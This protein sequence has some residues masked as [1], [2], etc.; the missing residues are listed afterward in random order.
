MYRRRLRIG[1]RGGS[2]L[3]PEGAVD[4]V[5]QVFASGEAGHGADFGVE[6]LDGRTAVKGGE[7]G[8]RSLSVNNAA[9]DPPKRIGVMEQ[10]NEVG[11]RQVL[12]EACRRTI[13]DAQDDEALL[14]VEHV[15]NERVV[16]F[17]GAV[18][19]KLIPSR[20]QRHNSPAAF[21]N[22]ESL[23][24]AIDEARAAEIL[25][26]QP[27]AVT[28]GAQNA[29]DL[30]GDLLVSTGARDKQ[31]AFRPLPVHAACH[32]HCSSVRLRCFPEISH[33]P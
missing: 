23:G 26:L 2:A 14:P 21:D 12:E 9:H 5:Q 17:L 27:S 32:R 15:V 6:N 19:A 25:V 24:H 18:L 10:R 30:L 3:L 28:G 20:K 31:L 22:L 16:G 7:I 8:F 13:V 11:I 29:V 4:G 1:E 33:N